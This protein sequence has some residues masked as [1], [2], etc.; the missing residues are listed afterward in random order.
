V[1]LISLDHQGF[2]IR[3]TD[4]YKPAGSTISFSAACKFDDR[5]LSPSHSLQ[6]AVLLWMFLD[7]TFAIR[8][9]PTFEAWSWQPYLIVSMLSNGFL[10]MG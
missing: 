8:E 9:R 3:P 5:R 10:L 4:S 2:I 6:R 1:D 7:S